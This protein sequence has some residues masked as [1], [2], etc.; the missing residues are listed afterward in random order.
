MSIFAL[1]HWTDTARESAINGIVSILIKKRIMT[2]VLAFA[3]VVPVHAQA[4]FGDPGTRPDYRTAPG[5]AKKNPQL[6]YWAVWL[7]FRTT[8]ESLLETIGAT[9]AEA[10]SF[11]TQI[12]TNAAF[13]DQKWNAWFSRN[14]LAPYSIDDNY[15][16]SLQTDQRLLNK[17]K[18]E[19]SEQKVLETLRDVALDLQ[20]KADNCRHSSDGL[21]KEIRVSVHTK[22][23]DKEV[24]GY[25]VFF[26]HKG[27]LDVK[28]AHDRFPRQSSPTDEKIL[29]PGG[30]A[31]WVRKKGFTSEPITMRIGGH[32]ETQLDVDIPVPPEP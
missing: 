2:L 22:A 28:R 13:L 16:A 29:S 24:G 10:A 8:T 9:N 5:P 3:S 11:L 31:M 25:E 15:L 19:K 32:G 14:R 18:K 4:P 17:L 12:Q 23:G 20:I 7:G 21:G 26:V 30:Y 1:I 27:M 6:D